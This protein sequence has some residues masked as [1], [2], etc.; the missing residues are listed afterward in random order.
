MLVGGPF[1]QYPEYSALLLYSNGVLSL[2]RMQN[3]DE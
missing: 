1:I 3:E 2:F